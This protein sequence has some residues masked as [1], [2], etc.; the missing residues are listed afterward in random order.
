MSAGVSCPVP[1]AASSLRVQP[2][3]AAIGIHIS[4]Y[5]LVVVL[6]LIG[7][8]KFTAGEAAG[9]QPLVAH[10]P[11]MSWMYAVLSVQGTSNAIGII[12]IVIAVL[13]GLRPVLPKASF[14]GSLGGA[15]TFLLTISFL[16]T[17][18][19]AVAL[20]YGFPVLGGAGQFLIK[21]LVLLGASLW[22]A[23]EAF[24]AVKK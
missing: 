1:E 12:E 15:I 4:R 19:G 7:V 16:F 21:D 9:I 20:K 23:A 18:P 3:L 14:A 5:G 8:L 22:T 6:L 11:L 17:T 2:R 13:I 10:S 24:A